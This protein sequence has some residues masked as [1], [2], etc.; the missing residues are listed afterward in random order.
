MAMISKMSD[1]L[2][3]LSDMLRPQKFTDVVGQ[4]DVCRRLEQHPH[5]SFILWG[6]PGTGKTTLARITGQHALQHF[7]SVSA[8]FDGVADLRRIF[9]KAQSAYE[10]GEKTLLFVDEI[11]RFNKAQQDALLPAIETGIVRLI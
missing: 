5:S 9:A 3:P 2:R 6:P 10:Q 4:E 1:E 8:V 11:H 7:M